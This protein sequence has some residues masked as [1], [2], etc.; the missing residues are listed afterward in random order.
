MPR[1]NLCENKNQKRYD[2]VGGML[3]AG[4]RQHSLKPKDVS[5]K[6]GM[7]ERTVSNYLL[8]PELIRLSDLYTLCDVAGIKISFDLK[9]V[10]E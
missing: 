10:P 9:D 5:A 3:S 1:T 7:V 6:T 8:H 2:Y 4:L